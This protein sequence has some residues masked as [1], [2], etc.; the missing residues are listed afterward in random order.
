M[1]SCILGEEPEERCLL[2][3]SYSLAGQKAWKETLAVRLELPVSVFLERPESRT[4][5]RGALKN[6]RSL[7]FPFSESYFPLSYYLVFSPID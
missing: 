5:H 2:Q 7:I 4:R 6:K 3:R 1:G